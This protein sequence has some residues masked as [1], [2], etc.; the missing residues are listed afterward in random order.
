MAQTAA[1]AA[2]RALEQG[3]INLEAGLGNDTGC[4]V[5]Q[6]WRLAM[7]GKE[8][9]MDVVI[10]RFDSEGT[11]VQLVWGADRLSRGLAEELE[12]DELFAGLGQVSRMDGWTFQER[13]ADVPICGQWID[14][15]LVAIEADN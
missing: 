13:L 14:G 4:R 3:R 12:P 8:T 15:E 9:A 11:F 6:I 5:G 10:R 1:L 2:H 7:P